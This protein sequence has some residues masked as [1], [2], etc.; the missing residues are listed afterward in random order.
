MVNEF[1][2]HEATLQG[3]FA[4]ALVDGNAEASFGAP[5]AW[6]L[7]KA[8]MPLQKLNSGNPQHFTWEQSDYILGSA[9]VNGRGLILVAMPLPPRFSQAVRQLEASQQR[10]DQ[11]AQQKRRVRRTYMGLLLLLTVLVLFATTSLAFFLSKLVTRPV[12][13]LAEATQEISRGRLDYRVE[14]PAADELGDLVQSFNRMAE[15]LEASRRQ[16]ESSTRDLG[17]ANMAL[18][19][20]RR[21]IETILESIPNGVLSLDAGRRVTHANH[22]LL[23]LFGPGGAESG[24]PEELIGAPLSDV[25]PPEVLR[26]PA[27]SVPASRSH[28][29]YYDSDGAVAGTRQAR[30]CSHRGHI[31]AR[32]PGPGLRAGVR[33]FVGFAEGPKAGRLAGSGPPGGA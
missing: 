19:Q 33:R 29:H 14:V 16:I 1:R 4:V 12:A 26:G 21:H 8:Q 15:D 30:R 24:T 23:R 7:L 2:R 18:E 10:Y 17:S 6:G 25:F 28:G 3:G 22:A 13:A 32:R 20:R 11:L 27:T 9:P 31:A 5:A